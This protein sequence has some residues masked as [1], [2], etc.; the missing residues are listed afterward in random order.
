MRWWHLVIG[1]LLTTG[2]APAEVVELTLVTKPEKV[3]VY[4]ANDW[5][6]T[7]DRPVHIDLQH[8]GTLILSLQADGYQPSRLSLTD[9]ELRA[10]NGQR[11][12][13][14]IVLQP[15]TLTTWMAHNS[16]LI[17]VV[18]LASLLGGALALARRRR[19]DPIELK[20]RELVAQAPAEGTLL[21]Q[22][23]GRWRLI[24]QVGRGGM[25]TV[26][27]A[28]P[29]E[30]LSQSE[31]VAVKVIQSDLAEQGDFKARFQREAEVSKNLVH[32]H[33]VRLL[34]HGEEGGCLYIVQE[35]LEGGNLRQSLTLPLT[36]EAVVRTMA[37]VFEAV[38]Y[39]HRQ[40]LIH[41]DLKPDNLMLTKQGR[42]VVT[43]FGLARKGDSENL[44]RTGAALGTPAY[45]A[46]EQIQGQLVPA[47]DQYALG[48][49]CYEL[50]TGQA[51]FVA[52]DPVQ[53]IFKHISD[54]PAPTGT[55]LDE[56]VLRMLAKAPEER[57]PDVSQAL[58]A[59]RQAVG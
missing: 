18:L 52:D 9:R 30:S 25:A 29:A 5:L 44:T 33:I 1:V 21:M 45:M 42:I 53:V 11:Y 13:S 10:L 12:P 24:E 6:G 37:P 47:S 49:I 26:Y 32:P 56:V 34:E 22:R 20:L 7:T 46:P 39:A 59:L 40:G 19:E 15:A 51:P 50:L 27:R 36:P 17:A 8:S 58:E 35:F 41:R 3:Q 57:Y 14:T 31:Q 28:L 4:L 38:A 16:T 54:E 2:P 55:R 23:I 48:I 43:D